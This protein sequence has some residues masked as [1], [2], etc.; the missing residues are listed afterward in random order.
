M[1]EFRL[2][3][4]DR[5]GAR[6]GVLPVP[7]AYTPVMTLNELPTIQIHYPRWAVGST[8]LDNDPEVAFEYTVDGKVWKEPRDARF[9]LQKVDLDYYEET[10]TTRYDFI[11]IGEATRGITIFDSYGLPLNDEGKP[12]FKVANAGSII[13][14]IWFNAQTSRG[15]TGYTKNH[16]STTDSNGTA[17]GHSF[18]VSYAKTTAMS[19]IIETLVAQGLV[20]T[21]WV[22]RQHNM[23]KAGSPLSFT[24]HT[25]DGVRF[26]GNG[27]STGVDAAPEQVTHGQLATH[28][29]VNGENN[30]RWVFP[31]AVSLPEGRREIQLTYSGVDDMATAE[32]LAG[33]HILRAQYALKNTTRQFHLTDETKILPWEHYK[34][35]DWVQVA[36]G[37]AG[38]I[39]KMRIQSISITVDEHGAQGYV[40][41]GDK[42]D[43]LLALMYKRIQALSGGVKNE[44]GSPP[45]KPSARKPR[46]ATGLVVGNSP[47]IDEAGKTQSLITAS[48]THDGKDVNGEMIEVKEHWF[49]YRIPGQVNWTLLTKTA[50]DSLTFGP[51]ETYRNGS[52]ATYEFTV[53]T[54]S[55]AG[56]W[57]AI[58]S[59][60]TDTMLTDATPPPVPMGPTGEIWMR[61]ITLG[62][63]GLGVGGVGMPKDFAYVKVWESGNASGT[64]ATHIANMLQNG[65]LNIGIRNANQ[66]YWYAFS[67]VDRSG[68]ES[69]KSAWLQLTPLPLL[70]NPDIDA[71]VDDLETD[72]GT[73]TQKAQDA[74]NDAD[75]ALLDADAA[76]KAA[77]AAAAKAA[78]KSDVVYQPNPPTPS[79]NTLWIDTDDGNKAKV[80]TGILGELAR[81]N[82]ANNPDFRGGTSSVVT[83]RNYLLNPRAKNGLTYWNVSPGG[84]TAVNSNV[85]TG[86]P[87]NDSS[88]VR[89]TQTTASTGGS[90][91]PYY[92]DTTLNGAS[93]TV[94]DVMVFNMYVRPSVTHTFN[95]SAS[96]KD[97][98]AVDI[99]TGVGTAVSCPAGVWTKLPTVT[100]TSTGD[101]VKLQAWARTIN[102]I[103]ANETID[104]IAWV[105]TWDH[106]YFDADMPNT[107]DF[108]HSWL[109]TAHLSISQ[110][111]QTSVTGVSVSSGTGGTTSG[112]RIKSNLP[113]GAD[114]AYFVRWLN[115]STGGSAGPLYQTNV[116]GS[117]GEHIV[118]RLSVYFSKPV[119]IRM[120]IRPRNGSTVVVTDNPVTYQIPANTW[121]DIVGEVTTTGPYTNIQVWP[122]FAGGTFQNSDFV[123]MAKVSF[124]IT[125]KTPANADPWFT[126]DFLGATWAGTPHGSLSNYPGPQWVLSQ[127]SGIQTAQETANQAIINAQTAQLAAQAAALS[128]QAAQTTADGKTTVTTVVPTNADLVGKPAGALWTQVVAGKVVGAWYKAAADSTSWTTMPFD[129][130]MIPQIN[131]GTGTF[132]DLD[133][134]RMQVGSIG[135]SKLLVTDQTS[136]IENGD[137]ETGNLKGWTASGWAFSN[138]TPYA[139][140]WCA[141]AQ[142][143]ND[144]LTNDYPVWLDSAE[145]PKPTEFRFKF[146]A[147]GDAGTKLD[148]QLVNAI[149]G[150]SMSNIVTVNMATTYVAE[151]SGNLKATSTG[152]AKLKITTN[153]AN[154]AS[155]WCYIDNVRNFKRA[156][157]ELFIDGIVKSATIESEAILAEHLTSILILTS[158]IVAGNP[159]GTHAKMDSQGFRVYAADPVNPANPPRE[160]VRM[161]VSN[162]NDY[163]GVIGADGELSA[164]IDEN[165]TGSFNQ[166][167]VGTGGLK[168]KGDELQTHLDRNSKGVVAWGQF[169]GNQLPNVLNGQERGLFEI[170]WVPD[171]S[172]M[173]KVTCS[174]VMYTP[175]GGVATAAALKVRYTTNG[176]QPTVSSALIAEDYKPVLANG[177]W[178]TSY[179]ISGRLFAGHNGSYVRLLFSMAASNGGGIT[180]ELGQSPT[181]WVE[182]V[183]PAYPQNGVLSTQTSGSG[184]GNVAVPKVTRVENFLST[185]STNYD[186]AGNVYSNGGQTY[187]Y[188]G[189]SPA[190]YGNLRSLSRFNP[191]NQWWDGRLAGATINYMRLYFYF[192]HWYNNAGGTAYVGVHSHAGDLPATFS[193]SGQIMYQPNWPKPGGYWL[194]I[195]SA[196][197]ANIAN[198]TYKGFSLFGDGTYGTYGYADR[199]TLQISYTK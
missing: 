46:P 117:A 81:I 138:T 100:V 158:Q 188:Q 31:T 79:V 61:S 10:Q 2:V 163:F 1:Q 60:V 144:S 44:G 198:A 80:W 184:S 37:N 105:D 36:R 149:T 175:T 171:A 101:F 146:W 82:L 115:P 3:A 107:V 199:P 109:G 4:Y 65:K 21:F 93:G 15:W 165:G 147:K 32:L 180:A 22:G 108:T 42:T 35:G 150:T 132:G 137:F 110:G 91:G 155:S 26:V 193:H 69:A 76:N 196:Y 187:M 145:Q 119:T 11:G 90:T 197:W 5:L 141:R 102:I 106:E 160:V 62:W 19:T 53:E 169:N 173:Y 178:T 140:T 134:I 41:L 118:G 116:A 72:I 45:P 159:L 121:T 7:L 38:G 192:R 162:S 56:V 33:P 177:S 112:G 29:V 111:S 75:Q 129:P 148:V 13:N 47:Y 123:G 43:E 25:T 6:R 89:Y 88:F 103:G 34:V 172:R 50:N 86:G 170:A 78:G 139:G 179:Q 131:I 58:A 156:N 104:T 189:L 67:S 161:G 183:G 143:P 49:F 94:G 167:Y 128:A 59:P 14:S 127:D 97:N 39:E 28:I 71:I 48:W 190:G 185:S 125:A 70:S 63:N 133:G 55:A 174:P 16:G 124:E 52:P 74:Q 40:T 77:I 130:V 176:T 182:D 73:A 24:D 27:N 51:I 157:G 98:A 191:G 166:V 85:L 153:A 99:T 23:V 126:G 96:L 168:Y 135:V 181:F 186:G 64:P 12:Q 142:G 194:D 152:W 57:S 154:G 136:Y 84:G 68:N 30:L 164:S 66:S 122:W 195:P 95:L 114:S 113:S 17:W 87:V 92:R 9:R 120:L 18:T 83:K 151:F 54:H 8:F 20:D